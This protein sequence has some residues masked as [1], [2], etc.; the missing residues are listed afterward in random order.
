L[1]PF[2][3]TRL[4]IKSYFE[5]QR[6]IR[7]GRNLDIHPFFEKK[8][9]QFTKEKDKDTFFILGGSQSIN[10][11]NSYQ[12]RFI[13]S[14]VSLG[15]NNW[16]VHTFVPSL[17]LVEGYKKKDLDSK[18]YSWKNKNL[19]KYLSNEKITL[20]IKDISNSYLDWGTFRKA[21][22]EI[23]TIPKLKV[24]GRSNLSFTKSLLIIRKLG[25]Q[26]AYNLFSRTSI[27][28]AISLGQLLDYKKI[29]L[30]G[31]DLSNNKY[32]WNKNEFIG[33]KYVSIPPE[34]KSLKNEAIHET[35][36]ILFN[37]QTAEHLINAYNDT[38]LKNSNIELYVYSSESILYPSIPV[39]K[40]PI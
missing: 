10:K 40:F 4:L 9:L 2:E 29:V 30:C 3:F 19:A 12:W 1:F 25:L 38:I 16:F 13:S 7:F 34:N 22:N 23:F 17:L 26:N 33:N 21:N 32:F 15:I 37:K 8:Y 36:N 6:E 27:I 5:Y 20:L 31:I 24:P 14:Q 11:I 18:K 39:Y 28:Q 35:S